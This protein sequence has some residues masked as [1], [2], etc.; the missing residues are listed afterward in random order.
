MK[1]YSCLSAA[2]LLV[3]SLAHAHMMGGGVGFLSG[4]SHPFLGLDHL[5]AMLSVG[6]LSTQLGGKSI[7]TVPSS[8]VSLMLLGGILGMHQFPLFSVE[9]GIAFSVFALGMAIAI[10]KKV[11]AV[12]A[13]FLVGFFAL[14][15]G[16]AHG[17][18]MPGVVHPA[19]YALGFVSATTV[20][21]L[22]GVLIGLPSQRSVQAARVLQYAGAGIAAIG[23]R[24]LII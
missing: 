8:F 10:E 23:L 14:F 7:W 6:I 15:H 24:L 18:E 11:P 20:V 2:F 19:V 3:P 16:H 13:M 4:F 12:L 22:L 1:K 5:L 9:L 21:H 17:S